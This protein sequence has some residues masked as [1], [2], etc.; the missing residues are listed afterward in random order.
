MKTFAAAL[1]L[2]ALPGAAAFTALPF[3]LK[4]RAV[5]A[6]RNPVSMQAERAWG[7]DDITPDGSL[8]QLAYGRGGFLQFRMSVAMSVVVS[9]VVSVGAR[10]S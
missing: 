10:G 9:V 6:A 8:V 5:R 1:S 7:M 3:N 2:A 4:A